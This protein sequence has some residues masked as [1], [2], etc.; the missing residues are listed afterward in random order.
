M[1]VHADS[2]HTT[3]CAPVRTGHL[4][5]NLI[6]GDSFRRELKIQFFCLRIAWIFTIEMY[7]ITGVWTHANR[8]STNS[9]WLNMSTFFTLIENIKRSGINKLH[10]SHVCPNNSHW[11][12][13]LS[14]VFWSQSLDNFWLFL[15][16]HNTHYTFC[17]ILW[18]HKPDPQ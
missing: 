16:I 3:Y 17:D 13:I 18:H 6:Y 1:H 12:N 2:A 8:I 7:K 10:A 14:G 11:A 4:R 9:Q 15:H 5:S